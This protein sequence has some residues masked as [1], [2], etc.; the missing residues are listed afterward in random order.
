MKKNSKG[1]NSEERVANCKRTVTI[2]KL[3]ITGRIN[4]RIFN[5]KITEDIVTELVC[6]IDAVAIHKTYGGKYDY[7]YKLLVNEK[8]FATLFYASYI[9]DLNNCVIVFNNWTFYTEFS[10]LYGCLVKN[11]V[12]QLKNIT[13]KQLDI[14]LD[15][16][17]NFLNRLSGFYAKYRKGKVIIKGKTK[18]KEEEPNETYYIG[19]SKQFCIYDKLIELEKSRKTYILDY[20]KENGFD[21]NNGVTRI[22]M[23]LDRSKRGI[24]TNIIKSID[25]EC[26]DDTRYLNSIISDVCNDK[27]WVAYNDNKDRRITK[28]L[29]NI[30]FTKDVEQIVYAKTVVKDGASERT[31]KTKIKRMVFDWMYFEGGDVESITYFKIG[32]LL[33]LHNLTEWYENYTTSGN[34][35]YTEYKKYMYDFWKVSILS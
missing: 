35:F 21:L 17:A 22:E 16:N 18:F 31:I 28:R 11:N 10:S 33:Q 8:H 32:K 30:D 3:H 7:C 9:K 1:R 6:K 20:Y 5:N 13:V 24:Y 25:L 2:D 26:L 27:F 4:S 15:V 12:L 23:H 29:I 34:K 14:A 19:A